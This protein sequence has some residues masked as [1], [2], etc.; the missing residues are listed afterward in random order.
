[1]GWEP[2]LA[3]QYVCVVRH[4]ARCINMDA[5]R[6]N[7]KVFLYCVNKSGTSCKNWAYRVKSILSDL[8]C[9]LFCNT[10]G[11]I[12][13]HTLVNRIKE[14]FATRFK[15]QWS[16][17]ISRIQ[18]G[19]ARGLNKLRTYRLFKT[20]HHTETYV[21]LLIPLKHRSAFAKFRCGVA[22]LRLETGRYERLDIQLRVCPF[23]KDTIEDELHVVTQC[24]V[25][26]DI[27]N[28]LYFR[29]SAVDALFNDKPSCDKFVFIFSSPSLVRVAAKS[30]FLMLR[31]RTA[32]LYTV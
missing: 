27:R 29:A 3:D 1:M 2:I 17:T 24:P 22:P 5:D 8:D 26:D 20:D 21:K 6:L 14:K 30:C 4:W 10:D 16:D 31:R 23:C 19:S 7:K 32:L 25:Y 11:N 15:V 9:N 18:S 28:D 13:K 12:C